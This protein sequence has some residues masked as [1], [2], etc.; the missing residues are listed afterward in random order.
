MIQYPTRTHM[1][2]A[3]CPPGSV[4]CEIGVFAAEF[5]SQLLTL[6]PAKLV[7]IDPFQG[8]VSS[9]D[10][11]GNNVKEL[12]LPAAYVGIAQKV[13]AH[14]NAVLLRGYSQ[15]FLPLLPPEIFDAVYIDGDHSYEGVKRDLELAWRTTKEGGFVCGHDLEMNPA[16]TKNRYDFGVK[17]AVTEFCTAKGVRICALGLDGQISF[18]IKKESN[19][20]L[21]Q[22][23]DLGSAS[24]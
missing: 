21:F 1:M 13:A 4:I 2:T 22:Y 14:P 10:A 17:R 6:R 8:K 20:N 23:V 7:L 18:A 24:K 3:L 16:K 12:F 19:A 9:G 15:E 11:D 5:A